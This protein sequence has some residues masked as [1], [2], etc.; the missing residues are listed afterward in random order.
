[1]GDDQVR[2]IKRTLTVTPG[3]VAKYAQLSTTIVHP[4]VHGFTLLSEPIFQ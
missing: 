1:M 3:F 4:H 2:E